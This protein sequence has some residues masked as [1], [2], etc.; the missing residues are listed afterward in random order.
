MTLHPT[1]KSTAKG[2]PGS[3]DLDSD[4]GAVAEPAGLCLEVASMNN[5]KPPGAPVHAPLSEVAISERS[6]GRLLGDWSP[7]GQ[8]K[9]SSTV[10]IEGE[11]IEAT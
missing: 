9:I 3:Q 10:N 8:H 6:Q 11:V 1:H 4:I 5:M 7:P 2:H